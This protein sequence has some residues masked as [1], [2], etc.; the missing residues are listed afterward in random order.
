MLFYI[1]GLH[2]SGIFKEIRLL[3]VVEK[4][5]TF[6]AMYQPQKKQQSRRSSQ[7][8]A[9][10]SV[11]GEEIIREVIHLFDYSVYQRCRTINIIV[12]AI[13]MAAHF[14]VSLLVWLGVL[15]VEAF[16][17]LPFLLFIELGCYFFY[18][19]SIPSCVGFSNPRES[20]LNLKRI[21]QNPK[22]TR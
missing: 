11:Q 19:D 20:L 6:E 18:F 14:I 22:T 7:A 3:E 13:L 12:K 10:H 4:R 17:E 9:R 5:Y 15:S 1:V 2:F 8:I 16:Y 21:H